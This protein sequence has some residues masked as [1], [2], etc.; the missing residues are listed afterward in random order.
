[1]AY[2]SWNFN[3]SNIRSAPKCINSKLYAMIPDSDIRK[4]LW[5]PTGKAWTMPTKSF[6]RYPYMNRKFAVEDYTSSVADANFMRLGE[7]YLIA[8]EAAAN[9]G[10]NAAAQQY[11]Y[12]VNKARDD[13]YQKST[14]TGTSLLEEIYIYRR[15]ELW[16][17]GHRFLDLKRLN[18]DLDRTGANHVAAVSSVLQIPASDERWKFAIPQDEID[19]NDLIDKNINK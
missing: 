16:G 11:L 18:R 10:D 14:K 13:E 7:M 19:A 4:T 1:M 9:L 15:I 5:D 17:E 2:M 6:T 12:T 8:A 3:S